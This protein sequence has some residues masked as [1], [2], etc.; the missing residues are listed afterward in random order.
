MSKLIER[1]VV[2]GDVGLYVVGDIHG[3]Y[4]EF[5][6]ELKAT[7]FNFSTDLCISVGD[8][9]DRGSQSE[10]CL[11]LLNEHWFR[12]VKG[13]HEDFCAKGYVDYMTEF[14]HKM[15]NNGG[16]WFYQQEDDIRA[17]IANRFDK[18]PLV[19]EVDY[20]GKKYGFV[21]ADVAVQDWELFK[22]MILNDDEYDGYS[23][24]QRAL[25]SRDT[26]RKGE[27]V[28]IAQVDEVYLGHTVVERPIKLGNMNFIDT[29]CVFKKY[30]DVYHLTVIKLGD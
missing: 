1:I 6:S 20:K 27:Q 8:I 23:V 14:Y 12:M 5:I 25:W 22:E 18:L 11:S 24:R 17:Y 21:H 9:V 3:C 4:D 7:G 15:E 16:L 28:L 29:G 19:I 30:N 13:N 2:D 10:K 26:I